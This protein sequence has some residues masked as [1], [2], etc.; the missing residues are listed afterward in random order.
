MYGETYPV[1]RSW[2]QSLAEIIDLRT[3][4]IAHRVN[5]MMACGTDVKQNNWARR[6]KVQYSQL[7]RDLNGN[8][9]SIRKQAVYRVNLYGFGQE[10]A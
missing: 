9:K 7:T 1:R 2:D 3:Q 4:E 6:S 5:R 8:Q 10:S